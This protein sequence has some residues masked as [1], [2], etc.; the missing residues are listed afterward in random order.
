MVL[1]INVLQCGN[2]KVGTSRKDIEE[3]KVDTGTISLKLNTEGCVIVKKNLARNLHVYLMDWI[4]KYE[5]T[6]NL[7]KE[8]YVCTIFAVL[9]SVYVNSRLNG[10][11][12]LMVFTYHRIY[13]YTG[14]HF[15]KKNSF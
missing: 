2:V 13:E 3:R 5:C 15:V 6:E 8:K 9:I 10:F 11:H 12:E 4:Q 1:E 14:E 7:S